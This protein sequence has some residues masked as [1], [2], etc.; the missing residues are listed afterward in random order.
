[1]A[2]EQ[3]NPQEKSAESEKTILWR[4]AEQQLE[5]FSGIEEGIK[6]TVVGLNVFGIETVNSCEG[7]YNHGR[8][9]PWV[10]MELWQSKPQER[11]VGQKQFEQQIYEKLG[12]EEINRRNWDYVKAHDEMAANYLPPGEVEFDKLSQDALREMAEKDEELKR[13]HGITPEITKIWMDAYAHAEEEVQSAGQDG[14]LQETEEYKQWK[15][16]N[17]A[18]K[19]KTQALLDEF[20]RGRKVPESTRIIVEQ[21]ASGLWCIHNGGKDYYDVTRRPEDVPDKDK[22]QYQKILDGT[23]PKKDRESIQTRVATYLAEFQEFT[24]FLRKKYFGE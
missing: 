17:D 11:F 13:I 4:A 9:A 7:H 14:R 1:M 10:S 12:V 2:G 19:D 22:K 3:L 20:Y 6:E 24:K 21:D 8:I 16:Q 18:M 15:A 23:N 5:K